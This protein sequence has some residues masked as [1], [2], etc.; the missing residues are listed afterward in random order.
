MADI[1]PSINCHRGDLEAV[2]A[3]CKET[4]DIFAAANTPTDERWAHFDVADGLFTFHKSWD[5]PERLAEIK[6][7]FYFEAHL[8]TEEPMAAAERW[9]AGGAKRIIVH[10]EVAS[11]KDFA[12]IV[13]LVGSKGAEI[14]LGMNPET[15]GAAAVPYFNSTSRFLVLSVHPGLSGQ[16]FLPSV[17]EK[18]S[19]LRRELPNA[20]I[21]VDGGI[22]PETGRASIAAGADAL[23]SGSDIFGSRDPEG[24]YQKLREI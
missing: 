12:E 22:T 7:A 4:A 15:P 3:R 11:P 23:V 17:L 20:K 5:E 9:L 10:L 16:K 18:I 6:P 8:M 19:F 21:E 14:A 1:L 24:E 13:A 2:R